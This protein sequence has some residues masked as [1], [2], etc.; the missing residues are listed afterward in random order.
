[1]GAGEDGLGQSWGEDTSS[2]A[3][4]IGSGVSVE[5]GVANGEQDVVRE[6]R[7]ERREGLTCSSK[8]VGA[9]RS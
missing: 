8:Y 5:I 6:K 2:S 9:F 7:D 1:M 3:T 4:Q